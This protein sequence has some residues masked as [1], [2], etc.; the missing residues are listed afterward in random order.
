MYSNWRSIL[1]HAFDRHYGL[2]GAGGYLREVVPAVRV[3]SEWVPE[4]LHPPSGRDETDA[5]DE[6]GLDAGARRDLERERCHR[7]VC[8]RRR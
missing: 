8:Q 7:R 6:W 4:H 3:R 5:K 2:L 1:G